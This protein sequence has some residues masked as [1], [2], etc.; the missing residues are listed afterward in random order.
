VKPDCF[1]CGYNCDVI[2]GVQTSS[3][4]TLDCKVVKL[5]RGGCCTLVPVIGS[6]YHVREGRGGVDARLLLVDP[7]GVS[8]NSYCA[9][10]NP[11][12]SSETTEC[13]TV[14]FTMLE[15]MIT[16]GV[17]RRFRVAYCFHN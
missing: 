17:D 10:T 3:V 4:D 6:M 5:A 15:A 13:F 2:T 7:A 11:L 16:V 9:I 12:Y 1:N 8:Q 14:V